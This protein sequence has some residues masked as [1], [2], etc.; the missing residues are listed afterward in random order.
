[1]Q[2]SI[3]FKRNLV[4]FVIS[5]FFSNIISGII[6][7]VYINYLQE[8]ARDVA[9]SFWTY[10]GYATFISAFMILLV[11]KI[12]YK[13]VLLF[14]PVSCFLALSAVLVFSNDIVFEITSIL[15]LV[16]LQLHFAIIAPYIALYTNND[17]KTLWYS[18][19]YYIGYTGWA[20]MTLFGGY[21]TVW[22][23]SIT[24]KISF[25][26]AQKLTEHLDKL[27]SI[28]RDAYVLANERIILFTAILAF[29]SIIPVLLIKESKEDYTFKNKSTDIKNKIVSMT[30]A[31]TNRYALSF[32]IYWS[33][34]S[35]GMG[36][37]TP[38]FTV[39]LNRNLHIDRATS[40]MLISISYIAIVLFVMFTPRAVKKFGQIVTIAG[41]FSLSIP[42]MLIIANGDMFGSFMIPVVGIALFLRS[43]L[44]NLGS[45]IDSSLQM[46]VVNKELRP[47]MSSLVNIFSGLSSILAGWFTGNIL[48][49]EQSGYKTAYYI[50]SGIYLLACIIL[51]VTCYKKFNRPKETPEND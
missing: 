17:N 45:P 28:Q 24:S 33:L 3:R 10:Y 22:L 21:L 6:Y 51:F 32:I 49:I 8:V 50:A 18:R 26:S 42:T 25:F 47:A 16:G 31:L 41:V 39:F 23:F 12:G 14:S 7:D 27:S 46:E 11:V 44:A 9:I 1:M 20:L 2:D 35:F 48:F 43:G 37:F 15:A 38:Y 30:K 4:M 36:L 34:V 29:I 13:K 40:S 19:A 5:F